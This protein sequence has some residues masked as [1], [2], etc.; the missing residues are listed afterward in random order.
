MGRA[1]ENAAIASLS[2]VDEYQTRT[3]SACQKGSIIKPEE[4]FR[5][6]SGRQSKALISSGGLKT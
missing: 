6:S 1:F 4:I 5:S 2:G 3:A